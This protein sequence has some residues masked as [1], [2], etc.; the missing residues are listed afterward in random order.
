[1]SCIQ[2]LCCNGETLE[3]HII[4]S[5]IN[6]LHPEI[7]NNQEHGRYLTVSQIIGLCQSSVSYR[8]SII[9]EFRLFK[10]RVIES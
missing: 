2:I 6:E 5:K 9:A 10:M 3:K 8:T 4:Y 1:M 7:R